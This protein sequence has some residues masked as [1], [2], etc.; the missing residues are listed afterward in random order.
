V[1]RESRR[2]RKQLYKW[3][4]SRIDS[5]LRMRLGRDSSSEKKK[6]KLQSSKLTNQL[7]LNRTKEK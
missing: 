5:L 7:T 4:W 2:K 3:Y 6:R 1:K